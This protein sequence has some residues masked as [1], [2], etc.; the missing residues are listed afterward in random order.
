VKRADD[1]NW[2]LEEV[3]RLD[4]RLLAVDESTRTTRER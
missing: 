4:L 2:L 3:G 1:A